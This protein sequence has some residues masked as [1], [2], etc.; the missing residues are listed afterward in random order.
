[1]KCKACGREAAEGDFCLP[2]F[3]AYKNLIQKY[4]CWR[5]ALRISWIEYLNEI[6][7]NPLTGEWI[8]EVTIYLI[9]DEEKIIG[10]KI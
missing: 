3:K 1:M 10:E 4:D 2:H 8:K 5:K 6:K 9:N 7:R